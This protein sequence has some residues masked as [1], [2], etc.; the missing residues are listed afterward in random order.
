MLV[1]VTKF[2]SDIII[3]A[4]VNTNC[5]LLLSIFPLVLFTKTVSVGSS[6]GSRSSDKSEP[7]SK[8]ICQN[9]TQHNW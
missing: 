5:S 8:T 6:L 9:V 4:I 2:V 1:V 7:L 3:I